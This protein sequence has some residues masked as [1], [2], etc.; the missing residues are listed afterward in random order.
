M[1]KALPSQQFFLFLMTGG[2]AAGVNFSSR[3]LLS[4]WLHFSTAIVLAYLLGMTTAFILAKCFVFKTSTQTLN[5]SIIY[6]SLINLLAITQTWLISMSLAYY[7]LPAL[8]IMTLTE[9]I[10]HAVGVMF[11]VFTSYLGHK[12][13]SFRT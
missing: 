3:I 7:V 5:Q 11:P 4:H 9:E 8:G 1:S 6:F 13:L 10:A 2:L 12:H